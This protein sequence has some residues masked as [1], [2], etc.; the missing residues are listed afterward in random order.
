MIHINAN[1]AIATTA[2]GA[3]HYSSI[4]DDFQFQK[5]TSPAKPAAKLAWLLRGENDKHSNRCSVGPCRVCSRNSVRFV[6][7]QPIC[8][9]AMLKVFA[10]QRPQLRDGGQ[11]ASKILQLLDR[12][13]AH[14]RVI[15]CGKP[16]LLYDAEDGGSFAGAGNGG[17]GGGTGRA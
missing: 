4:T 1:L 17:N 13:I 16:A 5:L 6:R 15:A 14:L 2:A 11:G 10:N 9:A 12:C 8:T 7:K 3:T